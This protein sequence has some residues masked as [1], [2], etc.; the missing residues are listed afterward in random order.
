MWSTN[1]YLIVVKNVYM[2]VWGVSVG[3]G[4]GV[5]ARV[6]AAVKCLDHAWRMLSKLKGT[7]GFQKV[8]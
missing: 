8:V 6:V 1:R 7:L 3:V 2:W 5:G 4:V